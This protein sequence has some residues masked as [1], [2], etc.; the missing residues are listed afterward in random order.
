M[1]D[2]TA[3]VANDGSRMADATIGNRTAPADALRRSAGGS[4]HEGSQGRGSSSRSAGRL[5]GV[6][7]SG[8]RQ[9]TKGN[10]S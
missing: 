8:G 6:D 3:E 1:Q 7:Y 4:G 5:R 2:A 9:A 10:F